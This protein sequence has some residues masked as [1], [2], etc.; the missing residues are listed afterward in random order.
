MKKFVVF[1]AHLSE[2]FV[3]P[4]FGGERSFRSTHLMCCGESDLHFR[5]TANPFTKAHAVCSHI[6]WQSSTRFLIGMAIRSMLLSCETKT[7]PL[8][9]GN[10]AHVCSIGANRYTQKRALVYHLK[11]THGNAETI[12]CE[13]CKVILKT[14]WSLLAHLQL[15]HG[16]E[17]KFKC[18]LC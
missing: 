8:F 11:Y 18:Q 2:K 17:R 13:I 3:H 7:E 14:R 10:N 1:A 4:S 16:D 15:V 9:L 12:Q 5:Y 6:K